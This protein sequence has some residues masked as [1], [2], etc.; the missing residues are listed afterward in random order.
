MLVGKSLYHHDKHLAEDYR[1]IILITGHGVDA[2][3]IPLWEGQDSF[4]KKK[5]RSSYTEIMKLKN[6]ITD[7]FEIHI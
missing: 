7:C 2:N 1:H 4:G 6:L 5:M 3:D